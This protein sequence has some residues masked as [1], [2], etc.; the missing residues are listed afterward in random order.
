MKIMIIGDI[1]GHA[2]KTALV[3]NIDKLKDKYNPDIIIANAENVSKGGKS[4]IK[5]DYDLLHKSGVDYF[6]MGNHTF[7]NPK[8]NEYIDNV[9]NLVRP[10]NLLGNEKGKGFIIFKF[11]NKK[12]LLLNLLGKAF[13]NKPTSNPFFAADEILDNNEYDLA[14]VDFHAEATSEKL[15][16]ANYLSNKVDI[17]VGT[18]T[19]VQT[20]DE[21]IMKNKMAYIT[22]L[23]MTG[24]FNSA[25]GMNYNEVEKRIKDN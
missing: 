21:R 11:N 9:D 25:I 18:H 3:N 20:S 1:F 14:I 5:E 19:H 13:I 12:I 23:G 8:I 4:L 10:A 15:V 24:V 6:T 17:F 22:D 16:L 7:D 2:G